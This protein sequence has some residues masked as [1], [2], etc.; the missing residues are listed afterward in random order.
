MA[1]L[2]AK[3]NAVVERLAH[4]DAILKDEQPGIVLETIRP[5]KPRAPHP[6]SGS[7][8]RDPADKR[9]PITQAILRVLRTNGVAMTAAAVVEDLKAEYGDVEPRRLAQNVTQ[10]LSVK[11]KAGLLVAAA[12]DDGLLAY[13]I[14]G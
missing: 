8:G 7:A 3:E 10:F 1:E 9:I 4:V 11:K 5:R 12:S 14:A 2:E 6:R 13:A